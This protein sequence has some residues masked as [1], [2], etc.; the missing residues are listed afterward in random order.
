MTGAPVPAALSAAVAGSTFVVLLWLEH[1]RPLRRTVESKVVRLG[2]NLTVAAT[3]LVVVQLIERPLL[4]PLTGL[5]VERSWGLLPRLALPAWAEVVAALVLMDYT[6]YVWH[7]LVHRVPWLWRFHLVHHVDR[8]LDASTALRFHPAEIVVSLVWRA[9]QIVLIGLSPL[10]FTT[11]QS[12]L[13]VSTLFHHA[14]VRL[15]EAAERWLGLVVVTPRLHGI[16]HSTVRAETDSNWSSGLTLWDRLHGTLRLDVPQ[17][18][19]TIGVPAFQ[20]PDA[21]ALPRI[22]ALPFVP[23]PP[24]WEPAGISPQP[25]GVATRRP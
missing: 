11:W 10:A 18:R 17:A 6:L 23:Q 8:D 16:H 12:A 9:G 3:T 25:A 4:A 20:R 7:V 15:P 21:V 1:R 2:R 24:S 19:I 13:L 5:V 14:N 22:L